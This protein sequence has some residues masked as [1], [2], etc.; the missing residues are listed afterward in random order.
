MPTAEDRRGH[1][2]RLAALVHVV[3]FVIAADVQGATASFVGQHLC[4]LSEVDALSS[5]FQDDPETVIGVTGSNGRTLLA[6]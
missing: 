1:G 5:V 3:F 2:T 4:R 6:A